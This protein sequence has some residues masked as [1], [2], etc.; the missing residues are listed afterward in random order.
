VPHQGLLHPVVYFF[1]ALPGE[2]HRGR[3]RRERPGSAPGSW[4]RNRPC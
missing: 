1:A 3:C 4:L 2:L